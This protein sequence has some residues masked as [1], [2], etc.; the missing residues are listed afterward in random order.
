M[1]ALTIIFGALVL[2]MGVLLVF[3]TAAGFLYLTRGN[4]VEG[5]RVIGGEK[6]AP[7]VSK[8]LFVKQIRHEIPTFQSLPSMVAIILSFEV[9]SH[10]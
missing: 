1:N 6:A 8:D 9:N 10:V 4:P 3:F 5:V 2:I 7:D